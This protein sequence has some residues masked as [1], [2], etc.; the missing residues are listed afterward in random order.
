M[1]FIAFLI[2][3]HTNRDIN[4]TYNTMRSFR[5]DK[6]TGIS[7]SL[8]YLNDKLALQLVNDGMLH[9]L[10]LYYKD[11]N[12]EDIMTKITDKDIQDFFSML[13]P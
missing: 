12:I 4:E 3:I 1:F 7:L 11:I 6:I 8:N 9:C 13:S 5:D 2:Y 10:K